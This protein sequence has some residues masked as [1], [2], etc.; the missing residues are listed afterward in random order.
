MIFQR[1][2][3]L[4]T[5]VFLLG[6][7][8]SCNPVSQYIK[9]DYVLRWEEDIQVFDSL[10]AMERSDE[11]TLLVTGS[12][13]IRLWDSIH[14][15]LA[16]FK[17]MQRG[18]GGARLTDFN[19]YVNR[20]IQHGPH[21]AILIFIANDIHGGE[22]DRT[23]QEVFLLFRTLVKQI[24]KNI[25]DSPVFWIE[26]TPA[27]S[28]WQ[29]YPNTGEANDLIR[30]YCSMRSDLHFIETRNAFLNSSVVPD[31]SLFRD[32]MLHLNRDGYKLWTRIIKQSLDEAGIH[33]SG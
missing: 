7:I 20:I 19:H 26:V 13:S 25:G 21:K 8:I 22:D 15:D 31:S 11:E 29:V 17:V 2:I 9:D 1:R 27:P 18:Y 28:R 14:S 4:V 16:P 32:D 10:N 33:P 5:W 24:R 6:C 3:R 30:D 12:S 23:P